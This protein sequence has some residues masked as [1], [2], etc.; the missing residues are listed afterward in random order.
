MELSEMQGLLHE[1]HGV[2]PISDYRVILEFDNGEYR[3]VSVQPYIEK[4]G[5]FEALK[6]PR[7][8]KTAHVSESNTIEWENGVDLDPDVLYAQS[9]PLEI[10]KII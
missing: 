6:D 9:A 8:F 7:M 10:P 4:G 1:I 3:V 5:V 2:F